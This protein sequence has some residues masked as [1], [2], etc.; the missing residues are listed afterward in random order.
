MDILDLKEEPEHIPLLAAWH[1][2]EW[3]SLNPGQSLQHRIDKMQCYLGDAL[4]PGTF[5]AKENDQLIGSAAIVEHDMDNK[6]ELSPW[7]A[8][9]FVD[10]R[11]RR[12]GVG[13]SLILHVM[14]KAKEAGIKTLYLFTPN[15]EAF[16]EK[17]G[18]S[19]INNELYLDQTVTIMKI[20]LKEM[21]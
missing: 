11:Y 4:I 12:K 2:H 21:K 7:L 6:P 19:T 20:K 15:E 9:V 17:L 8:S 16:Y 13:T 14:N 3:A 18:W 5:I 1:H 10:P